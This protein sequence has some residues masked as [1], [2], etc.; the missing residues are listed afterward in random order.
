MEIKTENF[1]GSNCTGNSG[2]ANRVL[3]L[4]NTSLT[5]DDAFIVFVS[6]LA[7]SS[8]KYSVEHKTSG[9]EITFLKPLWNDQSIIVQYWVSEYSVPSGP[10]S[11]SYTGTKGM[12]DTSL[13]KPEEMNTEL[14]KPKITSTRSVIK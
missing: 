9:T 3:T 11:S 5:N 1:T 12:I 4:S 13:V 6:G 14:V 7:V 8:D 10:T 2:E